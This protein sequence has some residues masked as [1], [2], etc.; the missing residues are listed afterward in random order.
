MFIG[1]GKG[2]EVIAPPPGSLT[3]ESTEMLRSALRMPLTAAIPT[4]PTSRLPTPPR[5]AGRGVGDAFF[6]GDPESDLSEPVG[7]FGA[8]LK[9][10]C[11]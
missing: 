7:E 10:H 8:G 9:S 3:G 4:S 11:W 2:V 1:L 5:A 6:L